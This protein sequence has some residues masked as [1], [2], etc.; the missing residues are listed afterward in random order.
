[1]RL[2]LPACVL[3][4][5]AALLLP[6][7]APAA[8][9]VLQPVTTVWAE[10]HDNTSTADGFATQSNGNLGAGPVSKVPLSTLLYPGATTKIYAHL[11]TWFGHPAHMNVGYRSDD[12]AQV[13]RQVGDMMSRGIHGAIIDWYGPDSFEN[14][15]ALLVMKE[16]E[17]RGNFEFA[18]MEDGGALRACANTWGCDVTG[19]LISD[20]K[21]AYSTYQQSY[22]YLQLN[23]RPVVFFFGEEH[24][25]I[26]W[27]RVRASVP[28]NPLFIFRNRS[29]FT[30]AQNDGGYSWVAPE[31][32][33]WSDP[34]ALRYLDDFYATSL[35]YPAK[36]AF[37]S[38]YKGFDDSLAAWGKGRKIGQQ[39]GQTWLRSFSE[40]N[41]YYSAGN[42]LD[43]LQLVTWNDYEE[44]TTLESG[45]DNCV[46]VSAAMSGDWLTW[47]LSGA[48]NTVNHFTVFISTDGKNLAV[49]KELPASARSLDL[50]MFPLATGSYTLYVRAVGKPSMRN[51]VSNGVSYS[52]GGTTGPTLTVSS[53]YP[54]QAVG[55]WVQVIATAS[56]DKPITALWVYVDSKVAYKTSSASVNT[57]LNMGSLG[58]HTVTVQAWDSSGAL[59]KK[60][61]SVTV[62]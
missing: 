31:T 17:A 53:P 57:W 34:M 45:V 44:G 37:A 19:K 3:A 58:T 56:S 50:G 15:G 51:Q 41:R 33:S 8:D 5:A 28:G 54:E 1:M 48:Q 46:R 4:C 9:L 7:R 52:R 12:P 32:V 29:A 62:K 61:M 21:Y 14:R 16:A 13:G 59:A 49:L 55:M 22:A 10:T 36:Y 40:I 60:S 26:D 23:G 2:S 47:S 42:Q 20:L 35:W 11:V 6:L 39:C 30:R 38:T 43:G 24:F 25:A 27:N 18:I